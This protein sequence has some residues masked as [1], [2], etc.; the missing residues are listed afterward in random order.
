MASLTGYRND[1]RF[2]FII[3]GIQN[4]AHNP[5]FF[6]RLCK[7]FIVFDRSGHNETGLIFSCRPD[8]FC[9]NQLNLLFAIPCIRIR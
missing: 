7:R 9:N 2:A 4:L 5:L 3:L 1:L 6:Q 8:D